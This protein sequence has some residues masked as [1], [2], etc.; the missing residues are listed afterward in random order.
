MIASAG[1]CLVLITTS[2]KE[3]SSS[4][5]LTSKVNGVPCL[6]GVFEFYNLNIEK[7][8]NEF[9][10]FYIQFINTLIIRG[11]CII[12]V[13]FKYRYKWEWISMSPLLFL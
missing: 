8:P 13:F 3:K 5:I 6:N 7:L 10:Q 1:L 12:G 4:C 9:L 11:R 2:F